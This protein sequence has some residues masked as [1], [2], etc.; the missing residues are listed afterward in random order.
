MWTGG[1]RVIIPNEKG[2][3]L[4]VMQHHEGKDIWMVP[5]GTIEEGENSTDAAIREVLEETGLLVSVERLI[6]HIEEVNDRRGQRFVNFF[7]AKPIGGKLE[8]GEDPEFGEEEQVL[9]KLDFFSKDE[10]M[11]LEHIYPGFFK[12]DIWN[13]LEGKDHEVYKVREE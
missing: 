10:I 12:D 1:V 6:W 8:L 13:I 3:I 9:E 5:G 11:K 2:E 7:L 4:M